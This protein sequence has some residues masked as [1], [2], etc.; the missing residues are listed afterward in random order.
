MICGTKKD[1]GIIDS[2]INVC[3]IGNMGNKSSNNGLGVPDDPRF[4]A[5]VAD[6]K[7]KRLEII[8]VGEMGFPIGTDRDDIKRVVAEGTGE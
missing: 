3:D 2:E 1:L 5:P 7:P 6:Q 4:L 8:P